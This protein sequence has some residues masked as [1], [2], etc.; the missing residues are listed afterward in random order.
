MNYV[1]AIGSVLGSAVVGSEGVSVG[2]GVAAAVTL[3]I[4]AGLVA[5]GLTIGI[6]VVYFSMRP[7][8]DNQTMRDIEAHHSGFDLV[9]KLVEK[10]NDLEDIQARLHAASILA[11]RRQEALE[12]ER[13]RKAKD[14][15]RELAK[16]E[17]KRQREQEEDRI[18]TEQ[19]QKLEEE[20]ERMVERERELKEW[21]GQAR[22][23]LEEERETA[24]SRVQ[25]IQWP[26]EGE[27]RIARE[28][29]QY[30]PLKF[31]FAIVGKAGSGKSSLVNSFLNLDAIDDGAAPT[32]ITETTQEIGRYQDPGTQL[33][34]PWTVW[35]DVPGAGTQRVSHWQYFTKQALF[36]FDI[37]IL[38]IGDRFEETDCEIVRSCIEF[39]IPFF[40]VRSKADQHIR[41]MMEED[42]RYSGSFDSGEYYESCRQ[43]FISE[44]KGMVSEELE[45]ASLPN[46]TVYCVSKRAL[47]NAY[48]GSLEESSEVDDGSPEISLVK[49]LM[50]AAYQRRCSSD[51]PSFPPAAGVQAV[52]HTIYLC[53]YLDG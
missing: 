34:R 47:R 30:D 31:H 52:S 21:I 18:R 39:K 42:S 49:E 48:N 45:R 40:I 28:K 32:G 2:F 10:A 19:Q 9:T 8:R 5:G 41:N 51:N 33:P 3:P 6:L 27:F 23:R 46:K 35:F 7:A 50:L 26:T 25:P 4:A 29:V 44:S 24:A 13:K 43:E 16:E 11:R 38:T 53:V 37:I 22:Q 12:D 14:R 17:A 36:V 1:V 15:T 20:E